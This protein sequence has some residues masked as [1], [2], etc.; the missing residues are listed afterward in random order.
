[1]RHASDGG[2]DA[3]WLG[4]VESVLRGLVVASQSLF[5]SGFGRCVSWQGFDPAP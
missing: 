1:M 3:L 5:L 4:I 2:V